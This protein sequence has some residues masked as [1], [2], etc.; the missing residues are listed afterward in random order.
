VGAREKH[1]TK[2]I[3]VRAQSGDQGLADRGRAAKE[4][5]MQRKTRE[6]IDR[7]KDLFEK[8]KS[9]PLSAGEVASELGL[10]GKERKQ[11]QKILRDLV[12]DGAIVPIRNNRYALGS[13]ADLVT[14]RLALTRSGKGFV[15]GGPAG[16]IMVPEEDLETALPGDIVLVRLVHDKARTEIAQRRGKVVKVVERV[17]RDI[18]GTLAST[19]HFLHVVPLDPVYR[20]NVYVSDAGG[21]KEGDRV[22]VRF[23]NWESRH[24]SPEGEIVEVI[25][26]ADN[27]TLDTTA[28]M[29]QHGYE[30]DFP[31]AVLRE[32]ESASRLSEQAGTRED[33]RDRLIL[34]IDPERARDFDDALSLDRDA[35][36]RRVLGVHIADVAHF[37]RPGTALDAEALKRGNS[38]YFP[39]RVIPMLPEQLSNGICSLNPGVDRLTFSAFLTLNDDGTVV[40]RRFA[41]TI[42]RSRYRMTYEEAMAI[43]AKGHAAKKSGGRL[44]DAAVDLLVALDVAAQQIRARR[45]RQFALDLDMPECEVVMGSD[46]MIRDIRTVVNDRSHQLVEEC[47]VAANEAVAAELRRRGVPLIS[48]VHEAPDEG[49]LEMLESD[50]AALGC[51]PGN[52]ADREG[53]ARF[54]D[55]VRTDPLASFLK[56]AVLRSMKR[57]MYAAGKSGHFG[58]AKTNYAHF[59]S[60]IRRYPD[61]TVHR[62]LD[63]LLSGGTP[64]S[65]Q[66]LTVTADHCTQTEWRADE[67]ERSVEEIKK[68]R[69]LQQMLDR[70]N[71]TPL[72]GVVVRAL[73]FGLMVELSGLQVQ[74]LVHIS[75]ISDRLVTYDANRMQLRDGKRTFRVGQ[76]VRV[77]VK[78]VDFPTRRID[79][80][81]A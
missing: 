26:P 73:N 33:L 75:T 48:R 43:L 31:E 41:K 66:D 1:G 32:A 63:A 12:L 15:S 24:V 50:L 76:K 58:L 37:V 34:T 62:Q 45:F 71:T 64:S 19:G 67:A 53:I 65:P 29:R 54:L 42:I 21:A 22:V 14:G 13:E 60:P 51:K 56:M 40:A 30:S 28:I 49:K 70:K 16:D 4:E 69:Y 2:E 23:T 38:V 25:G 7:I 55:K 80:L 52:L 35:Q 44:S 5:K 61:L 20:Q 39:D 72:D 68:F 59:T 81:L 11:L 79:F 10:R 78:K 77:S 57:A 3:G 18:V 46:G 6:L 27:P 17:R 47:M 8:E 36:G 9:K 74:G